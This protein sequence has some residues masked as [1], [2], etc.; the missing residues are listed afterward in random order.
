MEGILKLLGSLIEGI[1]MLFNREHS[2]KTYKVL[3][4]DKQK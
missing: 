1:G 4:K 3:T 2:S